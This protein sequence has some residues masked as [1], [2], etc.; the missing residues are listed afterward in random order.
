MQGIRT[1]P[2]DCHGAL[3]N[4]LEAPAKENNTVPAAQKHWT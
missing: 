1:E 2:N 4:D 3:F